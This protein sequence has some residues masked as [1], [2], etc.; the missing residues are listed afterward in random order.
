MASF[1]CL[2]YELLKIF[3][4]C[5]GVSIDFEEVNANWEWMQTLIRQSKHQEKSLALHC[6]NSFSQFF[7]FHFHF[8]KNNSSKELTLAFCLSS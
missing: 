1:W 8:L 7:N 5:F 3:P 6:F 2:S 4:P